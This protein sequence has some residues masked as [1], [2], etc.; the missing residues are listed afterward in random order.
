MFL[1]QPVFGFLENPKKEKKR[2]EMEQRNFA[3]FFCRAFFCREH[4]N[5]TKLI[6]SSRLNSVE[7]LEFGSFLIQIFKFG[8]IFSFSFFF[9]FLSHVFL[10]SKQS[11]EV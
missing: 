6:R 3:F 1:F 8:I 5:A 9:L 10:A 7:L 4:L 11:S 2:K